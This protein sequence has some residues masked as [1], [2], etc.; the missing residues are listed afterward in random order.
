MKRGQLV[1]VR[2]AWGS[3][4]S[5]KVVDISA[6]KVWVCSPEEFEKAMHERREPLCVGFPREDVEP[7]GTN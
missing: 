4:F 7:N 6:L 2:G 5:R 3:V 1:T